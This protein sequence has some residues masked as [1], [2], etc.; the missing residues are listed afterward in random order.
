MLHTNVILSGS[1]ALAVDTVDGR[2]HRD[3]REGPTTPCPGPGQLLLTDGTRRA[4]QALSIVG[5]ASQ[6]ATFLLSL[7]QPECRSCPRGQ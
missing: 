2:G 3:G 6:R 1:A 4:G 7:C 5:Q